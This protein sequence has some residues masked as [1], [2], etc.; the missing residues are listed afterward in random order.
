[1]KTNTQACADV[2][3]LSSAPKG[4]K[5]KLRLLRASTFLTIN[6]GKQRQAESYVLL[7]DNTEDL[8]QPIGINCN[9]L[10][11]CGPS[12]AENTARAACAA[13][14]FGQYKCFHEKTAPNSRLKLF[15]Y[16]EPEI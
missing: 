4:K 11:F 8:R 10:T 2:Q 7:H 1:M 16:D 13:H 15:F 14:A 5:G 12:E 9:F 6:Q 3:R